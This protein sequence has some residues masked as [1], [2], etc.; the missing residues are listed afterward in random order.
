[1]SILLLAHRLPCY[2]PYFLDLSELLHSSCTCKYVPKA[3][4]QCLLKS[5]TSPII[6]VL[7]LIIGCVPSLCEFAMALSLSLIVLV[8]LL[9]LDTFSFLEVMF[10]VITI[11]DNEFLIHSNPQSPNMLH[12][13]NPL[14]AYSLATCRI[15]FLIVHIVLSQISL[16]FPNWMSLNVVI[17]KGILLIAIMSTARVTSPYFSIISVRSCFHVTLTCSI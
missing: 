15:D 8:Y 3:I 2:G 14:A 10:N 1:M 5:I 4:L 12:I 7:G 11:S 13:R 17:I 6:R 9:T 16:A